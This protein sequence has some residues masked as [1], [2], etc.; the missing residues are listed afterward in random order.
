MYISIYVLLGTMQEIYF[1]GAEVYIK[2]VYM[3]WNC[4]IYYVLQKKKYAL[5][6]VSGDCITFSRNELVKKY[7]YNVENLKRNY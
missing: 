3:T 2:I 6:T 5:R 4:N 1:L 7:E